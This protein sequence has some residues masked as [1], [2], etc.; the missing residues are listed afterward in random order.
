M[1]II[2]VGKLIGY[3][4]KLYWIGPDILFHLAMYIINVGLLIDYLFGL[5]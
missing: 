1:C 5:I 3:L 4:F 2:N